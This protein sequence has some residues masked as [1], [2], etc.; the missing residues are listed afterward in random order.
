MATLRTSAHN[1]CMLS[2]GDIVRKQFRRA[3]DCEAAL[4]GGADVFDLYKKA[5]GIKKDRYASHRGL[6]PS[7]ID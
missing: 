2:R 4:R 1:E 3:R 5:N 7:Q 6:R